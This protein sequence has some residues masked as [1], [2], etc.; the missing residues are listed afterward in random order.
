MHRLMMTMHQ[1]G[2]LRLARTGSEPEYIS[3]VSSVTEG[4]R[5]VIGK[6]RVVNAWLGEYHISVGRS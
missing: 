5:N 1:L 6:S 2:N 3:R 4:N